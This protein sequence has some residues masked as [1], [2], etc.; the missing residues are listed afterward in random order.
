MRTR[1]VLIFISISLH[2]AHQLS[3][4]HDHTHQPG[5]L[6]SFLSS[7]A[8][9]LHD[10]FSS[11][12]NLEFGGSQLVLLE[13]CSSITLL[14]SLI[15][16]TS[17]SPRRFQGATATGNDL[18]LLHVFNDVVRGVPRCRSLFLS[19]YLLIFDLIHAAP[20]ASTRQQS[21]SSMVRGVALLHDDASSF[22]HGSGDD[23]HALLHLFPP[24]MR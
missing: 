11:S 17:R 4:P 8:L 9:L 19:L 2:E 14:L 1:C 24:V 12:L 16:R 13:H 3:H 18:V 5:K 7:R 23:H 22:L 6:L 10:S 21:S 20:H 15:H